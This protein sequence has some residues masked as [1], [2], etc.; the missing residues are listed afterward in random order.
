MCDAGKVWVFTEET[1]LGIW[2]RFVGCGGLPSN[3]QVFTTLA[4]CNTEQERHSTIDF[5]S[6]AFIQLMQTENVKLLV[7]DPVQA[8]APAGMNLNSMSD[9]RQ[10]MEVLKNIAQKAHCAVLITQHTAKTQRKLQHS[11]AGSVD[12][13]ASCRSQLAV[14]VSPQNPEERYAIHTKFN[15]GK[16]GKSIRYRI[17]Q[18]N[19]PDPDNRPGHAELIGLCDYTDADYDRDAA[20]AAS[21]ESEQDIVTA[22][23]SPLTPIFT[24]L[25]NDNPDGCFVWWSAL[26]DLQEKSGDQ[27]IDN[28]A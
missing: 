24:Q 20:R 6:P 11:G 13:K 15:M 28:P 26:A 9:V 22:D 1:L 18:K 27:I 4:R 10:Y 8:F 16:K 7:I 23:N 3:C 12:F 14:V 25:V 19:L 21:Q 2:S 17:T 5:E